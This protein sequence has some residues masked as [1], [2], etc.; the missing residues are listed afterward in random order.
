[1]L[2]QVSARLVHDYDYIAIE[3]LRIRNMAKN[4]SLARSIHDAGWGLLAN[5]LTYKGEKTGTTVERKDPR[6]T[7][8][9]C[10]GCGEP[11]PK[12][13]GQRMHHCPQCGLMLCRDV[14]AARNILA[15]GR[16]GSRATQYKAVA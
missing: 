7:T 5:F 11:V 16:A 3:N 2:H 9:D 10:S 8:V 13:L 6:N 12:G 1:V 4:H 14:N 15:R